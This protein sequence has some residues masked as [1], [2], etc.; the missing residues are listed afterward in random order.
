MHERCLNMEQTE[1]S[2]ARSVH[3]CLLSHH[4][5]VCSFDQALGL[6]SPQPKYCLFDLFDIFFLCG[7]CSAFLPHSLLF[8][9]SCVLVPI[10]L[11][12]IGCASQCF[13]HL[14]LSLHLMPVVIV[15]AASSLHLTVL[16]LFPLRLNFSVLI[17]LHSRD[18]S[19]FGYFSV[20]CLCLR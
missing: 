16:E 10:H 20:C 13:F 3:M 9:I 12:T 18:S 11:P 2:R 17:H 1:L 4:L 6:L 15:F 19:R 7:A 5:S 8:D 14:N